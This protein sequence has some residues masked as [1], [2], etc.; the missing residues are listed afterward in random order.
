[1]GLNIRSSRLQQRQLPMDAN[2]QLSGHERNCAGGSVRIITGNTSG[3]PIHARPYQRFAAVIGDADRIGASSGQ[4]GSGG[5][6]SP[7]TAN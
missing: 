2:E 6:A 5:C 4:A 7:P 1:M 3:W